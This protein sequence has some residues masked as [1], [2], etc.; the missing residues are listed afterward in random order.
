MKTTDDYNILEL[1]TAVVLEQNDTMRVVHKVI[2]D[3][4]NKDTTLVIEKDHYIKIPI[5]KEIE[6]QDYGK[7]TVLVA[8]FIFT[9]VAIYKRIKEKN[10]G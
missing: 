7:F 10:N 3:S 1:D 8:I 5:P 6:K 2:V 9:A 4:Q